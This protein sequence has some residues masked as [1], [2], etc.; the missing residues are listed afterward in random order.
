M[1]TQVS[2]AV[3]FGSFLVSAAW[4]QPAPIYQVTV[5]ERTVKAVNYQYRGGPT[6]IDFAG[7]VLLPNAKGKA[8]VESK[9]GRAEID[10]KLSNLDSP[11][12]YGAE[13][14][15]YVLWAITPEGRAQNLGEIISDASDHGHLA[16]TTHQQAFGM[17][18]TAE[19]YAAVR[20][21]SDVV[22]MEN[23]VRPDTIGRIEPIL[24]KY[25]LL[26]RGHYTFTKPQGPQPEGP[27][28]SMSR[29]ESLL[30]IYQAQNAI[31][32]ARAQGA[33]KYAADTLARADNFLA[34]A[35]Q[36]DQRNAGRSAVVTVAREAAQ[37]AEDA[38][39]IAM[40][41]AQD[42]QLAETNAALVQEKERREAAEQAA[43]NA[44]ARANEAR[45]NEDRAKLDLERAQREQA[46]STPAPAPKTRSWHASTTW[47]AVVV[48]RRRLTRLC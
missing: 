25:A 42:T 36:L 19:P 35:R 46:V 38:R 9:S 13:Y 14:L 32:I 39:T 29:Y 3:L 1:R 18:V 2:V 7:T 45:A 24:A 22:V 20:Q 43:R 17:I 48:R 28:V 30:E 33:D 31:Q 27:K 40:R 41:R 11:G 16:V 4:S 8:T 12:R 5:I 15:T 26:P 6:Q 23:V 44:E 37:T 21:P 47:T 34:E 10:A